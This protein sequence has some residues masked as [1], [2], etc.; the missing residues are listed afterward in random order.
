MNLPGPIF[1]LNTTLDPI[2][3]LC[4]AVL[5]DTGSEGR[6]GS[7]SFDILNLECVPSKY[8]VSVMS[9]ACHI[10][11]GKAQG[12]SDHLIYSDLEWLTPTLS[13]W[14]LFPVPIPGFVLLDLRNGM[15]EFQKFVS[16][17]LFLFLVCISRSHEVPHCCFLCC[18]LG[19]H[20]GVWILG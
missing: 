2:P 20:I 16:H 15:L 4:S 3:K 8:F 18:A 13:S 14:E 5:Q 19:S 7:L 9:F 10:H 17:T 6:G 12:L 11:L 1:L